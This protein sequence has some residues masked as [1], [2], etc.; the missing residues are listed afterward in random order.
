[1]RAG[2]QCHLQ[3]PV[4]PLQLAGVVAILALKVESSLQE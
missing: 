3:K 2:F 1:L 4:A